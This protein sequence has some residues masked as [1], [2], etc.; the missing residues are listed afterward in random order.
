[1]TST[2]T[3]AAPIR[4]SRARSC[5]VVG[6]SVALITVC[7]WFAIPIG[8][9]PLTLQ[10]FAVPFVL[11]ILRPSE[12]IAAITAYLGLGAIGVPLFSGMRGGIGVIMGPTGGFLIGY[13]FGVALAVLFLTVTHVYARS[14]GVMP[15]SQ[16]AVQ[17]S[18]TLPTL[19]PSERNRLT[20]WQRMRAN[21]MP[22][23]LEI[24][25]GLIFTFTAYLTGWIQYMLVTGMSL[26]VAFFAAVAPFI[27][28]D[29][30]KVVVAVLCAQ[31]VK[32]SLLQ[33]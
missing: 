21:L 30:I 11:C 10:M 23:G 14:A 6:L 31:P 20:G 8:P 25:A 16:T 29:I 17:A 4:Y 3:N 13:L 12:A 27:I 26:E 22:C 5:A 24:V 18:R 15:H 1:M 2:N 7:S 19:T 9:V 28:P 33:R 32:L